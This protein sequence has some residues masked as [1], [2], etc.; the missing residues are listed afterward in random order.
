MNGPLTSRGTVYEGT[1][2]LAIKPMPHDNLGSNLVLRPELRY[3]Y[4]DQGIF[5]G[6]TDNYQVTA[7]IDAIFTF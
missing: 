7:A 4:S 2:G 1:I 5:D 6:G 3:D